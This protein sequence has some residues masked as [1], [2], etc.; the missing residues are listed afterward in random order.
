[1][2]ESKQFQPFLVCLLLAAAALAGCAG[3]PESGEAPTSSP[4]P[5]DS[6][7]GESGPD[8]HHISAPSWAVGDWWRWR[9][10]SA[11]QSF[12]TTSIVTSSLGD[13]ATLG[14]EFVDAAMVA[15]WYHVPP[16]GTVPLDSLAWLAHEQP[17]RFVAFP[18]FDGKSYEGVLEGS[19]LN[20]TV[21]FRGESEAV[22]RAAYDND[23]PA[24]TATYSAAEEQ[25]TRIDLLYGSTTPWASVELIESGT[26]WAED[27][28]D[29]SNVNDLTLGY[30]AAPSAPVGSD[31][32]A[33]GP[34]ATHVVFGC[35]AGAG[36][37]TYQAALVIGNEPVASCD[38][39]LTDASP[40]RTVH[41]GASE[42]SPGATGHVAASAAGSGYIFW[43]AL[44]A[45]IE[46]A[47]NPQPLRS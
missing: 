10:T 3:A 32:F 41:V 33:T 26:G 35:A 8:N 17:V 7:K 18:L 47:E 15:Q 2:Q 40:D 44:D 21:T 27:A 34:K 6:Q 28:Y 19:V 16:S 38:L 30:A 25:F 13:S 45:T 39:R 43:E 12:E 4:A 14:F 36:P 24:L 31:D 1:M 11:D 20:V 5:P 37:G 42:T 9:L 46:P 23:R 22:L 29:V